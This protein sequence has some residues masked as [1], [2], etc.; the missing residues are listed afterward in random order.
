MVAN[1]LIPAT[2]EVE[3]WRITIQ[4]ARPKVSEFLPQPASQAWW[5]LI[6]I[7]GM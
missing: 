2:Q 7:L 1:A 4:E 3:I 5:H 6:I